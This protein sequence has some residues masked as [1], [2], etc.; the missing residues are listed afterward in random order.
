MVQRSNRSA[1]M[2]DLF[3]PA[4]LGA[5]TLPNRILMAPLTRSRTGHAGVPGPMNATYYAQR[6]TA[7]AII[8]EARARAPAGSW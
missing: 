7:G 4:K 8:A 3:S 1:S 5:I 2:A 6:A